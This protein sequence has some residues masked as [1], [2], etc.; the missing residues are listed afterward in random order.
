MLGFVIVA[1]VIGQIA[2]SVN[3]ES[4]FQKTNLIFNLFNVLG[5][6]PCFERYDGHKL[7]HAQPFHSEWK[8][9]QEENCLG[10]CAQA[11]VSGF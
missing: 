10:F 1:V 2:A 11:T 5:L 8:M 3:P 7:I 9:N 4:L 6:K